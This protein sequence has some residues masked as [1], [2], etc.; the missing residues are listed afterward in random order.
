[1]KRAIIPIALLALMLLSGC[2]ERAQQEVEQLSGMA[3]ELVLSGLDTLKNAEHPNSPFENNLESARAYLLGQLREK[4]GM[5]F[6]VVGRENLTN[7]GLF[8]GASYSCQVAPVGTLEQTTMALVSQTMYQDVRDGYAVYYFQ[9]EAEAP[10]LALCE[11]KDYV[12]DQRISLEMPETAKTWT[13]ED[14]VDRFLSESGAYVKCVLRLPDGMGSEDY[15]AY[16]YD[17]INSV[18]QLECN[19]LLQAKANKSYIFHRE[20]NLLDSFDASL[21]TLEKLQEEV[22]LPSLGPVE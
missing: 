7:Y 8:A 12:I 21:Y 15:A 13:P 10:I 5:E 9:E 14:G 1:M 18:D 3:G 17:F 22:E 4:Y 19:L 20:L 2:K 16:L 11:T 6:L